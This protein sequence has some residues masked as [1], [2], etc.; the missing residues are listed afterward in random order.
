MENS[1]GKLHC[2]KNK[3]LTNRTVLQE[4]CTRRRDV[5]LLWQEK[6]KKRARVDGWTSM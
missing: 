4:Y 6:K 2:R 3:E 5:G 1:R